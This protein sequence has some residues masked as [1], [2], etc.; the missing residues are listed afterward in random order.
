MRSVRVGREGLVVGVVVFALTH[1]GSVPV[2]AEDS[3]SGAT[4]EARPAQGC[5]EQQPLE[6]Q[7]WTR[8]DGL[9]V[10]LVERH[11]GLVTFDLMFRS[12]AMQDP[13]DRLGLAHLT[14]R[15]AEF[16]TAELERAAFDDRLADL[17]ARLEVTS[18]ESSTVLLGRALESGARELFGLMIATVREPNTRQEAFEKAR[19]AV[20]AELEFDR[21]NDPLTA[22]RMFALHEFG[23]HPFGRWPQGSPT[24]VSR[25]RAQDVAR[26]RARHW[27]PANAIL[28]VGG[29]MTRAE[30][31]ALLAEVWPVQA[32]VDAPAVAEQDASRISHDGRRVLLVDRPE[33]TQNP[34]VVGQ[35]VVAP[36]AA[37]WPVVEVASAVLGGNFSSRLSR[38]VRAERGLTYS[39]GTE[40]WR[41]PST[42]SLVV[43]TFAEP[44]RALEV[45]ELVFAHL[46]RL[47]SDGVSA[48]E[49]E[50]AVSY[51]A[52]EFELSV[53]TPQR[54]AAE[55]G[56]FVHLGLAAEGVA[57]HGER[58]R[59][60]TLEEV[61]GTLREVLRPHALSV[62][63]VC[64]ASLYRGHAGRLAGVSSV[65]VVSY[66]DGAR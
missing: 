29:A 50:A 13:P 44:E 63:M 10:V 22:R 57:A 8:E 16:G 37:T 53:D 14:A 30:L 34:I 54:L 17:G 49:L 42:A 64:T 46:E 45:I 11:D 12:G 59:R 5:C 18:D 60:L 33:R 58:L 24:S 9:T 65:E 31:E 3:D 38:D 27:V 26:F 36:S 23:S 61:N 52:G 56:R 55:A 51:V 7:H 47:V 66:T 48:E 1:A 6:V 41:S 21:D 28:S 15:L 35:R 40:L 32:G 43:A 62:A 2:V 39:I 4:G 25:I 19:R 20:I